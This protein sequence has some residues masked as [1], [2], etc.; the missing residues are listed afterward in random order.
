MRTEPFTVHPETP[1]RNALEILIDNDI[2]GLPVVDG[3]GV[4]VGVLS[5]TDLMKAFYEKD[6]DTV[7]NL[8]TRDP[9]MIS[10]DAPLVDVLDCLM[11]NDFRRVL[12]HQERK[13]VGL[14]SRA[15]LMPPVLEVLLERA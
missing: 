11:A 2:S 10:V 12:I 14:I 4:I 9:V 15:D 3:S 8:M 5:D 13:L 1:L 7:E 6:A